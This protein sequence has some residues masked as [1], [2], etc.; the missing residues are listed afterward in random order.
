MSVKL[1]SE[2]YVWI[3]EIDCRNMKLIHDQREYYHT[4]LPKM[5]GISKK[6]DALKDIKYKKVFGTALLML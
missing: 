2:K 3:L 5:V 4:N 6:S 1:I